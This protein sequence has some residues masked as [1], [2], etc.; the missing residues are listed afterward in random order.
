MNL[1]YEIIFY[2]FRYLV[3]LKIKSDPDDEKTLEK[4]IKK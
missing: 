4:K 2:R 1:F 3:I